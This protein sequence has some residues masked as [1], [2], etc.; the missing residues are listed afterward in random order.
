MSGK[1]IERRGGGRLILA[2][3]LIKR[4]ISVEVDIVDV[5]LNQ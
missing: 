2:V 4:S 1:I 5:E 3:D